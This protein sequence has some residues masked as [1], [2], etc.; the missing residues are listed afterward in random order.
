MVI[1]PSMTMFTVYLNLRVFDRK[2]SPIDTDMSL[3]HFALSA[4]EF[5]QN[6]PVTINDARK[7]AD[8]PEWE[9][10]IN[11]ESL[12]KNNTWSLCEL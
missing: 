2:R 9:R 1:V 6:D 7:C 3:A 8:W 10:A 5:V 12:V 4:E 11:D